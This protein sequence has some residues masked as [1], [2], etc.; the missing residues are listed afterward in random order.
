MPV[1]IIL[2]ILAFTCI[3]V[4]RRC[5][6]SKSTL[7]NE[8]VRPGRD[9]I[10]VVIEMSPLTYTLRHDT[11]SGFDYEIL[12]DI[13]RRHS[14]KFSYHPVSDL[15]RAFR[16]LQGGKYDLLVAS[17]SSTSALKEFFPLTDPVY[18]DRQVLVQRRNADS[19]VAVNSQKELLGDTVWIPDGAPLRSRMRNLAAELGGEIITESQPE[20]S[21]E[22]LCILTALGKIPRAVVNE[23]VARHLAVSY[24][25][26]DYSVPVSLNRF[27]V[28]AVAPGD[29]V[30]LDSINTWLSEFRQTAAY[31]SLTARYLYI[32]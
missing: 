26:L 6:I 2:I 9:T 24:P 19:T 31:D 11:A 32:H 18:L 27:Q 15:D 21:A 29:S 3:G 28:W 4:A 22:H 12:Q 7:A 13:A 14:V 8:Y 1:L 17:L 20:Y 16:G 25:Q 10:A 30:L 5:T 23:N